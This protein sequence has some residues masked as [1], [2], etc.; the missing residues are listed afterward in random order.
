M[1]GL[2]V[3][4]T[5]T[6]VGKT[7]LS[8][9]IARFLKN[10]NVRAGVVKPAASGGTLRTVRGARRR[11]SGD[12][13]LLRKA[14]GSGLSPDRINPVC[15]KNPLAPYAAS[16]IEKK[17]LNYAAMVRVCRSVIEGHD[18]TVAEGVGGAL[19]PLTRNKNTA[20]L[21]RDLGLPVIVVA[22][23]KLGT[24]NHTLLTLEALRKRKIKV[25][26]VVLNFY[27]PKSL[28]DRTNLAFFREKKIPVLAVL[29]ED[30]GLSGDFDRLAA[31]L[32]NQ[33]LAKMLSD[34]SD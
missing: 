29:P 2:F 14:S 4:G 34:E 22:S 18:F 1:K 13:L 28:T 3:T 11:V 32:E 16:R 8:C 20:D 27:D 5:G 33:V 26:G 12:A 31:C 19:V 10:R 25:W 9:A 24:L 7:L 6:E 17:P 30:A 23:S 21:M 15:Y